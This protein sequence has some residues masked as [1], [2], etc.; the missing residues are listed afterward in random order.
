[1]KE[2][3]YTAPDFS[4]KKYADA[5]DARFVPAPCD[6]VAPE[7]FHAMSIFPEYFKVDGK[8]LLAEES[9]MDCDADLTEGRVEVV[10]FRRLKKGD[11]VCTGRTENCEDGILV[12]PFGFTGGGSE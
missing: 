4:E 8:W 9:R 10:E 1:M 2:Y 7:D 5:P 11:L 6:G 12:W 3:K